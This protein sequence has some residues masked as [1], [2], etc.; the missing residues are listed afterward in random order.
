MNLKPTVHDAETLG[1]VFASGMFA[2]LSSSQSFDK[3]ALYSAVIAGLSAVVH[4][5]TTTKG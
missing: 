2:F 3:A 4:K 1:A 5:L